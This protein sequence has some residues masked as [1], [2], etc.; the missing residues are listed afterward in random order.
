MRLIR[1]RTGEAVEVTW[2]ALDG[3]SR[4]GEGGRPARSGVGPVVVGPVVRPGDADLRRGCAGLLDEAAR[5]L[6]PRVLLAVRGDRRRVHGGVSLGADRGVPAVD[7]FIRDVRRVRA[8]V[9]PAFLPGVPPR[10]PG[11]GSSPAA[12]PRPPL[13]GAGGFIGGDLGMHVVVPGGPGRRGRGRRRCRYCV[14]WRSVMSGWLRPCSWSASAACSTATRRP[15]RRRNATRFATSCWPH[16]WPSCRS[17]GS[18]GTRRST[19]PGWG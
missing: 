19:R 18:C 6:G 5:R 17:P 3:S 1:G 11:A 9:E 12:R 13:R 4:R 16:C 8:G 2:D 7:F 10:K 15:G 14:F